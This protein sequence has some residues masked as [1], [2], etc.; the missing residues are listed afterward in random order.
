MATY[1]SSLISTSAPARANVAETMVAGTVSISS[2]AASNDILQMFVLPANATLI[3][4]KISLTD[5]DTNGSPT[6]TVI[7][8]DS[9]DTDRYISSSTIG[10]A[11]GMASLN[12]LAGLNYTPTSN[13][14]VYATLGSV[15]TGATGTLK[16][17]ATYTFL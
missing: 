5:I 12:T 11:G 2:A 10:Q 3:D 7:V 13:T 4:L 16:F 14:T 6:A 15:A 9:G 17:N 1:Q 8:G